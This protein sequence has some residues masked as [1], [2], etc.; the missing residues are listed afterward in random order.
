MRP[1]LLAVRGQRGA[2]CKPSE[3]GAEILACYFAVEAKPRGGVADPTTDA[4][5]LT[6]VVVVET[7]RDLGEVVGLGANA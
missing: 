3:D 6:R 5:T 4:L 7:G 1:E 2:R